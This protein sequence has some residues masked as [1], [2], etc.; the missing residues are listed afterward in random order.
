MSHQP[1]MRHVEGARQQGSFRENVAAR[2]G[3][4][5]LALEIP[6]ARHGSLT[7]INRHE[8]QLLRIGDQTYNLYLVLGPVSGPTWTRDPLQRTGYDKWYRT[9]T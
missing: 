4:R 8:L 2:F 6:I 1:S 7:E 3:Q 5:M 9:H